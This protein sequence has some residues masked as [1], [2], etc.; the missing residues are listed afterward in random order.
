MASAI[1]P[2]TH[3]TVGQKV[4]LD[5]E[6][7]VR[8]NHSCCSPNYPC[9][10]FLQKVKELI[11]VHGPIGTV[12][13]VFPPGYELSV[14]ISGQCFHM[15]GHAWAF[16]IKDPQPFLIPPENAAKVLLWLKTRGGLALWRSEDLSD[17]SSSWYTPALTAEGTPSPRPHWKTATTPHRVIT[18]IDEIQVSEDKEVRRFHIAIRMGAQGLRIKLT[19]G[20]TKRVLAAEAK[21]GIGSYHLFDFEAQ[22]AVIMAPDK[23]TPLS[24]WEKAHAA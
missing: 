8:S 12:T 4:R 21:A 3:F 1:T 22:E 10:S 18:S 11:A 15:K 23:I 24:E 9:D 16:P 20:S 17:P 19:S 13:H 14:E 6:A 5:Y 7:M 2:L